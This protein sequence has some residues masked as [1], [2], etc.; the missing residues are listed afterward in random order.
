MKS[1]PK[2]NTRQPN[3]GVPIRDWKESPDDPQRMLDAVWTL[4][5]K[6]TIELYLQR[7]HA[8]VKTPKSRFYLRSREGY[9]WLAT[10]S[11]HF[12][13]EPPFVGESCR[14]IDALEMMLFF[15]GVA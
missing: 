12:F 5:R 9:D 14:V 10:V 11:K 13:D 8:A 7:G 1:R 15:Q 4:H 2:T 6:R 3:Q